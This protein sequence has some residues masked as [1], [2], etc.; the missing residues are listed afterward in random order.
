MSDH[1]AP[2]QR[3]GGESFDAVHKTPM[4]LWVMVALITLGFTIGAVAIP[5]QSLVLL[6][7]GIAMF[8]VSCAVAWALGIMENVH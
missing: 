6:I 8:V 3:Q 4:R 1:T 5:L 7:V 2:R